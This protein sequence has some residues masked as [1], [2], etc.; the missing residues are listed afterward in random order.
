M[1]II[2]TGLSGLVGSRIV[3]LLSPDFKFKDLSRKTGADI[4]SSE[5]I[6]E[7]IKSLEGDIVFHLAA[8]TN[9]D[10]AEKDKEQK[11]NSIAWKINVSGTENI[12]KACE[13]SGK[14]LIY[15]STDMVFPGTK[16]L[17]EKYS[18][19]ET[20]GPVG[21][22]ATTKYEAEKKVVQ[23]E[24]DWAIV[25]IAYPYRASFEKKEYVRVFLSLLKE[26][27]NFKAIT[28][29]FFTPTFIDDLADVFS[30]LFTHNESGI[31]HAVGS[32]TVSPYSAAQ[33]IAKVFGFDQSLIG[34]TT[35]EEYFANK[36]P[37]VYNL[38]LNNAKIE[39]FGIKMH[40]FIEGLNEIKKQI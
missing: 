12:I 40:S 7:K 30:Y 31:F 20:P 9:V 28:D 2:G 17:G 3:E 32:E 6:I 23:C 35:R 22:Y 18:E 16:P 13:Q 5:S 14:K 25:R 29:H 8:Y 24:A 33:D 39:K 36:A 15:I 37:R 1:K 38:S 19:E 27:K 34:K 11:E 4:T 21:W 26:G 10:E